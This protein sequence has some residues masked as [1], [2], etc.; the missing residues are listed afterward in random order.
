MALHNITIQPSQTYANGTPLP[1]SAVVSFQVQKRTIGVDTLFSVVGDYPA[2]GFNNVV[3][4][5]DL[6][7]ALTTQ[8]K[9]SQT[10]NDGTQDLTGAFAQEDFT[11]GGEPEVQ[12]GQAPS[13]PVIVEV[14]PA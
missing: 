12:A 6:P 1:A 10:V 9:V 11:A 4:S 5:L 2:N 13:A 8:I 14:T 7:S 3:A